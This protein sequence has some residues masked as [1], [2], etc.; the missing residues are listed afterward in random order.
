MLL[1][2]VVTWAVWT[3]LEWVYPPATSILAKRSKWQ[4]PDKPNPFVLGLIAF[5]LLACAII[6]IGGKA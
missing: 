6:V 2:V 1:A 5:A 3:W 4:A